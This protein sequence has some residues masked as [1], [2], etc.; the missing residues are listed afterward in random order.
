MRFRPILLLR[1]AHSRERLDSLS[2][3][4]TVNLSTLL[5]PPLFFFLISSTNNDNCVHK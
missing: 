2:N 1:H 3:P 4:V 5:A